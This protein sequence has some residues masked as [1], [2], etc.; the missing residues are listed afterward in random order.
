MVVGE[1][2]ITVF[3][4]FSHFVLFFLVNVWGWFYLVWKM[5][6]YLNDN[7]VHAR[8]LEET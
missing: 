7:Q 4:L 6:V 5:I 1:C 2:I 3:Q 8:Q